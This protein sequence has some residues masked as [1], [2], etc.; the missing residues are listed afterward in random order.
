MSIRGDL[1][2]EQYT[3]GQRVKGAE[4]ADVSSR[5]GAVIEAYEHALDIR[6][7]ALGPF[8]PSC[9]EV[10]RK[11]AE[12][13]YE[14]SD[15]DSCEAAVRRALGIALSSRGP[16]HLDTHRCLALSGLVLRATDRHVEAEEMEERSR[17]VERKVR[18][19]ARETYVVWGEPSA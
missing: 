5:I 6:E 12:F 4:E 8:H 16:Y 18:E 7:Q 13:Y 2:A 17:Q 1:M 3:A 19:V 14:L 10:I 9:G 15:Y 11:Q